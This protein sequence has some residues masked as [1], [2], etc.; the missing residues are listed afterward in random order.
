MVNFHLE[1]QAQA[2]T[3]YIYVAPARCDIF[4]ASLIESRRDADHSSRSI[5]EDKNE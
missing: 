3:Q 4:I 1:R 2:H 5:A